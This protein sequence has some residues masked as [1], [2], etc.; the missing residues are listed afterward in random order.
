MAKIY[1]INLIKA[2]DVLLIDVLFQH[3]DA[4]LV[5]DTGATNTIIDLNSL[6]IAGYEFNIENSSKK[7]FETANG[8]IEAT[9]IMIDVLTVFDKQFYNIEIYT[10]DFIDAGIISGYEGVL[11]LDILKNFNIQLNFLNKEMVVLGNK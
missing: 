10:L 2:D 3:H 1:S 6:L 4:L 9:S 7:K 5:L 8:V 11:G